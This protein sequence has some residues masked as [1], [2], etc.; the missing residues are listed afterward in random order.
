M[1]D[2]TL[3]VLLAVG[4]V[5]TVLGNWLRV[6][7]VDPQFSMVLVQRTIHF[8]GTFFDNGI[9]DHGPIE[10]FLYDIAARIGGRNGAWYVV[11]AMV[12]G[13]S[14]VLAYVAA[15]VA[16]FTGAAREVAVAVG[17]AVFVHFTISRSNYAG[18]LYIRN[19]TTCLLALAFLLALVDRPWRSRRDRVIAA[20]VLGALLGVAVQSLFTTVF[21]ALAVWLVA[22]GLVGTRVERSARVPLTVTMTASAALAFVSA[23]V[24]YALRGDFTQFWSGWVRYGHYMSAGTGRNLRQQLDLGWSQFFTYYE[25]RPLAFLLI[26]A[27]VVVTAFGTRAAGARS[28][29]VHD[30]LVMW[31]AAGWVELI[32]S[33]RYSAEYF[34][35]TAVPTAFM[36]AALAGDLW[37]VALAD[38]VSP[39]A[40]VVV[41]LVAALVAIYLSGPTN[42]DNDVRAAWRFR[43]INANQTEF[44]K[45][46]SGPERTALGLL[47]LVSHDGDPLLAWTNDPWPYLN[48]RR[49]AA[50]RLFYKSFMMGEI[51]LGRTSPAYVLPRTWTWFAQDMRRSKPV[52]YLLADQPS[53]PGGT[54]FAAYVSSNFDL[55]L[56]DADLPVSLRHDV[57]RAVLQSS[58]TRA[59]SGDASASRTGWTVDRNNAAYRPGGSG[60]GDALTLATDSCFRLEGTIAAPSG[61]PG[62]VVFRFVDNA[63]KSERL[64]FTVTADTVS[65]GSD[66]AQ[67]MSEPTD[68]PAASA[69]VPFA[70]VVG[71][72]S[73]ALVINGQVRAAMV[74][75][76]SV[77][78]KV[79]APTAALDL[80]GLRLG[81]PPAG[82]GC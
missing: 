71:R 47:D 17:A 46:R 30:G 25:K 62:N 36:A 51:Y 15:T 34:A 80:V 67:F 32:L 33:Q 79:D 16:R 81:A 65:S 7:N 35:V 48:L 43:G 42:F 61:S 23:P 72:R 69:R 21:A 8:G 38:R 56:P 13:V 9:Q 50:T 12:T 37:R 24:Y 31:W 58:A 29:I 70:L 6:Q 18:V 39:R 60:A 26:L 75:P 19:M 2:A 41:P 77:T 3:P 5:T 52:A 49:V 20:I 44:D 73:S 54:P 63:G 78:V 55:V 64:N 76:R 1:R 28:R 4:I 27:F 14:L 57:A 82:S 10:P 59:W 66:A 40:L 22:V 53:L 11:S 68:L 45:N 74:L